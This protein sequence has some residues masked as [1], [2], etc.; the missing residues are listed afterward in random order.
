MTR[1]AVDRLDDFFSIGF[2][3]VRRAFLSALCQP[4]DIWLHERRDFDGPHV[5]AR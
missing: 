3:S 1:A 4:L 5:T 2:N